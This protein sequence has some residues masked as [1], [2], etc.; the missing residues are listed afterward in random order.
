MKAEIRKEQI[1]NCAKK[2]FSL[3]GYYGTQVDDIIKEAG[4]AK[5]TV[6]IYFKNK[7]DIFFCLLE[8]F[9]TK[10]EEGTDTQLSE[11]DK[12]A[13]FFSL[14]ENYIYVKMLYTLQYFKEDYD[15]SN[16]LLRM[17]PGVNANFELRFKKFEAKVIDVIQKML[18]VGQKFNNIEKNIPLDIM[19]N[20]L[21]G[22][23]FR[24]SYEM[25]VLD[26]DKYMDFNLEEMSELITKFI[27]NGIFLKTELS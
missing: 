14:H 19:A 12:G 27:S 21:F 10:W 15:R 18:E 16:I 25:F 17:G 2:V 7:E 5:G 11:I 26:S 9:F 6:Y 20:A 23:I 22:L 8:R 3:K 1:L 24:I 4:I 13:P